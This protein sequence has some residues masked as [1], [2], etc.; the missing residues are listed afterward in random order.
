[1]QSLLV[2]MSWWHSPAPG[3]PLPQEKV[4]EMIE[5][6]MV[7][8]VEEWKKQ[9]ADYKQASIPLGRFDFTNTS[10][11]SMN[12]P[13]ATTTPTMS[14]PHGISSN[15]HLPYSS[16]KATSSTS[17]TSSVHNGNRPGSG[18]NP[19]GINSN[20]AFSPDSSTSSFRNQLAHGNLMNQNS[21][22]PSQQQY[23][24]QAGQSTSASGG[25][26]AF[27]PQEQYRGR[28][29]DYSGA[30][31]G[32]SGSYGS[33]G[34]EPQL[35]GSAGLGES[36]EEY[37]EK[38]GLVT[39][40]T[41][42]SFHSEEENYWFHLRVNFDQS[43]YSLILYRLYDD[44]LEFQYALMDEHPIEAGKQLAEG[45][46]PG[47]KPVRIIPKMPGPVDQVDEVVCAQR[48]DDLTTYLRG[49]CRLPDY[50]RMHPL[51]YEFFMLRPGDVEATIPDESMRVRWEAQ[52]QRERE[53]EREVNNS[54]SRSR[55]LDEEVV[56]YLDQMGNVTNSMA[57]A[58][59]GGTSEGGVASSG[60]SKPTHG[61]LPPLDTGYSRN[62]STGGPTHSRQASNTSQHRSDGGYMSPTGNQPASSFRTSESS[63]QLSA[64]TNGINFISPFAA[65]PTSS[66]SASQL[67]NQ[68]QPTSTAPGG[69]P[70]APPFVK[71]KIFHRNTDDLI[72]IRVPP[73]IN[74]EALLEK[75]RER[76]GNDVQHIRYREESGSQ[77]T[78]GPL[79][80][81]Q[82]QTL[83]T[84]PGGAR[85]IELGNDAELD[86]WI[87]GAARLVAYVD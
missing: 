55:G 16:T 59:L 74:L 80:L 69:E 15:Q 84:L 54:S 52:K 51:F 68:Q 22:H 47:S 50:L 12:T 72:A 81:G 67:Q 11:P 6:G 21:G 64:S 10:V 83:I 7:P 34:D 65:Q 20:K 86:D 39:S 26:A 44:F 79:S 58:N 37:Y 78:L 1:M 85:L 40:A 46:P 87:R 3:V 48:V 17:L 77:N 43:G 4:R 28:S 62:G 19:N 66:S 33:G 38:Y 49:L 32:P 14:N 41:V 24:G 2:P 56:E 71:I 35:E 8:P 30:D 61:T 45:A 23:G 63:N 29:D 42:E 73:S 70:N 36:V 9:T 60:S 18:P 53:I 82:N 76:L 31:G 57:K 25:Y 5:S 75:V 13:A 27:S